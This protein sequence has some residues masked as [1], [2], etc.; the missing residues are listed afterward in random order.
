MSIYDNEKVRLPSVYLPRWKKDKLYH[1]MQVYGINY[2]DFIDEVIY[3]IR[4][5]PGTGTPDL[6]NHKRDISEAIDSVIDDMTR[7][8]ELEGREPAKPYY[9]EPS[10]WWR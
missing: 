4:I 1:W 7:R 2:H 3:K 6:A 8:N 5:S 10:A 9:R